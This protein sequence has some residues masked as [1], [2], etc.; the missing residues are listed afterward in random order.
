MD[1]LKGSGEGC[2]LSSFVWFKEAKIDFILLD[3]VLQR[4]SLCNIH[5]P[6]VYF[7]RSKIS[8]YDSYFWKFAVLQRNDSLAGEA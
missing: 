6:G 4:W 8:V 2:F 7:Y 3:L 5:K 1:P